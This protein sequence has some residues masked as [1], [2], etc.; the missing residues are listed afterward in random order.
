MDN[1]TAAYLAGF[2]DGE[3]SISVNVN[4]KLGRWALRLTCHQVNP[5][6]L[7]LLQEVFGGSIRMTYRIGN[8]RSIFEWVAS[9]VAGSEALR[10]LRPYLR[11]KA[12]EAEIALQF[13][14]LMK[15]RSERRLGLSDEDREERE[16]LYQQLRDLKHLN[17][18]HLKSEATTS[19]RLPSKPKPIPMVHRKVSV[20]IISAQGHAGRPAKGESRMPSPE[21]LG[22]IY[23]EK[24]L[25][26]AAREF[27]VSR[28]TILNWLDRYGIPRQGRTEASEARRK[29]ASASSW[30]RSSPWLTPSSVFTS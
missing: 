19:R 11:V 14:S 4:R 6:P 7:Q 30:R 28:Q 29:A 17:Y 10:V 12:E 16:H 15:A 8:Q 26:D 25:M 27:G 20:P 24:G 21:V 22:Q 1:T 13:Q 3:G 18:E 5:R 9:G 23:I 2:F